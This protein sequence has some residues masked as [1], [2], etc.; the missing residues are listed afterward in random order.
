MENGLITFIHHVLTH[1]DFAKKIM[2][3]KETKEKI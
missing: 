3:D 2:K 1:S